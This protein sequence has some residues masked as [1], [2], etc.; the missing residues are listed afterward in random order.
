MVACGTLLFL[1]DLFLSQSFCRESLK[2]IMTHD[3]H[4]QEVVPLDGSG[5]RTRLLRDLDQE[6][7]I[8]EIQGLHSSL[9]FDFT[10]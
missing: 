9:L 4:E 8:E 5:Q 10:D 6:A 1:M 3:T 2:E 7:P